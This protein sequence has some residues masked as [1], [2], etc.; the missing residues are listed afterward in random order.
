MNI[1]KQSD[2]DKQEDAEEL[3]WHLNHINDRLKSL[4]QYLADKIPATLLVLLQD[5]LAELNQSLVVLEDSARSPLLIYENRVRSLYKQLALAETIESW[6]SP[7]LNVTFPLE[8]LSPL[9]IIPGY[10]DYERGFVAYSKQFADWFSHTYYGNLAS[11]KKSLL[12]SSGMG[13]I[14]TT[15]QALAHRDSTLVLG[16]RCYYEMRG[17]VLQRGGDLF[18]TIYLL[19]EANQD[20]GYFKEQLARANLLYLDTTTLDQDALRPDLAKI[21]SIIE[22]HNDL[23]CNIV[24]DNTIP[25]PELLLPA[26]PGNATVF[27]I[28]SLLK[29]YQGGFDLGS[30]GVLTLYTNYENPKLF[31]RLESLR[32]A[33]GTNINPFNAR[34]L[35]CIPA[36][37]VKRRLQRLNRNA[38]I[39]AKYLSN[40]CRLSVLGY[41]GLIFAETDQP[42]LVLEIAN[43]LVIAYQLYLMQ[44]TS[45]GFNCTRICVPPC[46]NGIIRVA[47]GM[48]DY[49]LA[50]KI[51][52]CL[53]MAFTAVKDAQVVDLIPSWRRFFPDFPQQIQPLKEQ[54]L[55]FQH[56]LKKFTQTI[57]SI[58][59]ISLASD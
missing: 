44:G 13:A 2:Q 43:L 25:G 40:I 19:D 11:T 36:E 29:Y 20:E 16:Q 56:F 50:S 49:Q 31:N 5:Q 9:T 8:D 27:I 45:F 28:E 12:F 59:D 48:E 4:K 24:L 3:Y 37:L 41:G 15:L 26:P 34:L 21:F 1:N 10:N 35:P 14:Q 42:E 38:T 51:A 57:E 7:R 52:K 33:N 46:S 17:L 22:A 55:S 53:K 58:T 18:R 32:S 54:R 47:A 6:H 30:A 23:N 39:F